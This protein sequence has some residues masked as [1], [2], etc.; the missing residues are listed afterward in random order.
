VGASYTTTT[1]VDATAQQGVEVD[2]LDSLHRWLADQHHRYC[3]DRDAWPTVP[4]RS[5][6][7]VRHPNRFTFPVVFR[8]CPI[9]LAIKVVRDEHFVCGV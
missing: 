3:P 6:A 4:R 5:T 8:R 7:D 1:T 9:C 2:S